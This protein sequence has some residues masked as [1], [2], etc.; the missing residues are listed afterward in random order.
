VVYLNRYKGLN[1]PF[2]I[3]SYPSKCPPAKR[4]C[5]LPSELQGTVSCDRQRLVCYIWTDR[6][7]VKL[8]AGQETRQKQQ[9]LKNPNFDSDNLGGVLV[10]SEEEMFSNSSVASKP[11]TLLYVAAVTGLNLGNF[12][13]YRKAAIESL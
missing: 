5:L 6:S 3:L 4:G 9:H 10:I 12:C 13:N 7:G 1:L 2:H 8:S 11:G